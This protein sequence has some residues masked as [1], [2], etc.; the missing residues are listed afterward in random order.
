MSDIMFV[1]GRKGKKDVSKF[2]KNKDLVAS[3]ELFWVGLAT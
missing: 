3:F 2:E 1:M